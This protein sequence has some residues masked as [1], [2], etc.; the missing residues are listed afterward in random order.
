[1]AAF[2]PPD[3]REGMFV[4]RIERGLGPTP[5]LV[6]NGR[7]HDVSARAPTVAAFL[8]GW[9]PALAG[10]DIGDFEDFDF[11]PDW[12]DNRPAKLLAPVDLQCVKAAGVTFAVSAIERVIEERARGDSDKAEAIRASHAD[13][14]TELWMRRLRDEAYVEYKL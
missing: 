11:R 12:E 7:V 4:G 8:E 9:N 1:M 2:L 14:E 5:I 6:R 10:A 3:W 13:E